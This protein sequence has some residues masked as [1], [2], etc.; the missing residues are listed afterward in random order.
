MIVEP[1]AN[2]E[3]KDNMNPAGRVYYSFFDAAVHTLF[4]IAGGRNVSG[5][6][7]GEARIR[8]VVTSAGF[9]PSGE[10][11]KRLSTSFT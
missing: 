3:L 5:L 9:S 6:Q 8:E 1:F 7:S 2:N 10:R 4:V 11:P